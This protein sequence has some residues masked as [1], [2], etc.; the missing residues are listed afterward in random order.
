MSKKTEKIAERVRVIDAKFDQ[1]RKLVFLKIKS[2]DGKEITLGMKSRELHVALSV[3]DPNVVL[4]DEVIQKMCDTIIGKEINWTSYLDEEVSINLDKI[5]DTSIGVEEET[6]E[7]KEKRI[8]IDEEFEQ[9]VL[10]L[11]DKY[12]I[13]QI[14]D[15]IEND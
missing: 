14:K 1:Q 15:Y 3:G 12:P 13:N 5:K 4:P 2:K 10:K 7:E 9:K 8:K 11:D 6:E